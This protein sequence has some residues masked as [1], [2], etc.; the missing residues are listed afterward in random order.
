MGLFGKLFGS[1][2]EKET[3]EY[4]KALTAYTPVFTNFDGGV[5]EM[6]LVR[7]AIHAFANACSK[8]KPEIHGTAYES[9]KNVLQF[10]PN[11]Y[12]DTAKFLYRVATIFS[13]KNNAFIVPIT[14]D[15]GDIAGYYPVL[16][17]NAEI[18][19][20]GGTAYIRF[21][22]ASGERAAVEY[23]KVAH[24]TQFQ[25]DNDFFGSDNAAI[26]HTL[27]L[28]HTQNEGIINAV[29]NSAAARFLAKIAN[30]IAPEKVEEE[31]DRFAER[32]FTNKNQS[33][34]IVHDATF[35]DFVQID[36]K[37]YTVN[38]AQMKLI[39]DNVFSYFGVN[40][41]ILQNNFT[42]EEWAAFYSGKIE[43]FALQLSLA[44]TNMTYSK[45]EM[46]HGN[47]ITL[48]SN[49]LQHMS[50]KSKMEFST[51]LVDRG[52]VTPNEAREVWGYPPVEGGDIRVVRREY[53]QADKM[54]LRDLAIKEELGLELEPDEGEGGDGNEDK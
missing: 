8:L 38:A 23:G 32:N 47:K 44:L 50:D 16:P 53:V 18:L 1:K 4:F 14:D 5:Y 51:T 41:K 15:G 52:V 46:A 24:L 3:A 54:G 39:N 29:K 17:S 21:T 7:S 40:E 28:I 25:M 19:D 33:G 13:V 34:L 42:G 9:L 27:Q 43:P 31:R 20:V 11:P 45:R 49:R 26:K 30:K 12:M 35:T 48:T 22:F 2:K 36:S 10:R 6:E 37:P